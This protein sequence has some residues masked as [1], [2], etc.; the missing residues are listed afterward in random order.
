MY[1]I[2]GVITFWVG[3]IG[4]FDLVVEKKSK[5]YISEFIFGFHDK[6]AHWFEIN[7]INALLAVFIKNERLRLF[8]VFLFSY[9]ATLF[10][11][12]GLV[13]FITMSTEN[14][15]FSVAVS[16]I[17]I[18]F[19]GGFV[20]QTPVGVSSSTLLLLLPFFV[21]PVDWFSLWV[22]KRLF[23]RKNVSSLSYFGRLVL[24]VALSSSMFLV[25]LALIVLE[26]MP[27]VSDGQNSWLGFVVLPIMLQW[28]TTIFLNILQVLIL[29]F[30]VILRL[31]L[32]ATRLNQYTVLHTRLHEAPFAFLGLLVGLANVLTKGF[33]AG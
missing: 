31:V 13:I 33:W 27:D 11:L 30:G 15:S 16:N 20:D 21:F 18:G 19:I 32:I 12:A 29:V 17:T 2:L 28:P 8:R 24:D 10:C 3:V 1:E 5:T 23:W 9:A 25:V 7:V 4:F 22:T 26:V 6:T 14:I